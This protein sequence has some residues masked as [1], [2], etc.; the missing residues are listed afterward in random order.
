MNCSAWPKADCTNE[1][2][3]RLSG[4]LLSHAIN[5]FWFLLDPTID[6]TNYRG[7]QAIRP[8]VVNRKVSGG[9][10]AWPGARWQSILMSIVRTC[11]QRAGRAFDYLIN[12]LS[13]PPPKPVRC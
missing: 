12:T 5:W 2:N 9:N 10:R 8:A 3:R 6:G 1:P 11:E 13:Q 4:H 7:E